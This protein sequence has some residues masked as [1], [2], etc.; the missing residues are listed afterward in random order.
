M[1]LHLVVGMALFAFAS[2]R[3]QADPRAGHDT[4][5]PE[6]RAPSDAVS[7]DQGSVILRL[8]APGA[9]HAR[10]RVWDAAIGQENW[11]DLSPAGG[12]WE[13]AYPIPSYPTILYYTFE[14]TF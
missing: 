12:L 3:G 7:T 4:F 13:L 14:A 8:W 6:F 2:A 1:S 11:K 5:D 9:L 10:L